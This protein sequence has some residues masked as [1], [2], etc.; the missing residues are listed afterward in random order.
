MATLCVVQPAI[1]TLR[2]VLTEGTRQVAGWGNRSSKTQ[3]EI[4]LTAAAWG[5]IA[6]CEGLLGFPVSV[7]TVDFSDHPDESDESKATDV[8]NETLEAMRSLRATFTGAASRN[9]HREL[10]A[11]NPSLAEKLGNFSQ[12][13]IH[14]IAEWERYL[15][16]LGAGDDGDAELGASLVPPVNEDLTPGASVPFDL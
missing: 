13:V 16:F 6:V 14:R 9:F 5:A 7:M 15:V 4:A 8:L 3:T 12:L 1:E 10:S 11:R 2:G